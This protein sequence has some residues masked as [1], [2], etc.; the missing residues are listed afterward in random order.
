M[1]AVARLRRELE[2]VLKLSEIRSVAADKL[3]MSTAYGQETVGI[4]FSWKNDVEA[5]DRLLPLVEE[6]LASFGPR[7]HWG[8]LFTMKAADIQ[9]AYPQMGKFRALV[10]AYD[11]QGKFRNDFLDTTI[12]GNG[13]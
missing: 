8:K 7:P 5:V 11:P 12:F 13:A 6:P 4:H 10:Q 9:A 3:W 2:P 1:L